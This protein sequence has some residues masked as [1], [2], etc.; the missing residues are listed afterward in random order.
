MRQR[1]LGETTS[2]S[3]R[4]TKKRGEVRKYAYRKYLNGIIANMYIKKYKR[5]H[6]LHANTYSQNMSNHH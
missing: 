2:P 4:W 3:P 5:K 6:Y 1:G